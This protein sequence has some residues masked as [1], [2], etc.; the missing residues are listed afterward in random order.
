MVT[1]TNIVGSTRLPA[2]LDDLTIC[3]TA[4]TDEDL[5]TLFDG[6]THFRSLSLRGTPVSDA[7]VPVFERYSLDHLDLVDTEVT[8]ATPS[9][10]RDADSPSLPRRGWR[11]A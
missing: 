10:F 11:T 5:I 9:K 8:A 3:L 7:I 6:V 1:A 2:K 4:A